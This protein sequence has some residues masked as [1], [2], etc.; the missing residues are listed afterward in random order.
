MH[1]NLTI[2][3]VTLGSGEILTLFCAKDVETD[4]DLGSLFVCL[5]SEIWGLAILTR[6]V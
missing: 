3:M 6:L 4:F 1:F 5:F 2:C